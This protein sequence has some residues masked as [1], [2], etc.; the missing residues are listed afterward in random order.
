MRN[1]SETAAVAVLQIMTQAE[2]NPISV[3]KFWVNS[4][5]KCNTSRQMTLLEAQH[6]QSP[7]SQV[8]GQRIRGAQSHAGEILSLPVKYSLYCS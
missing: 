6:G 5:N 8:P 4:S 2:E 7:N 3:A 1:G